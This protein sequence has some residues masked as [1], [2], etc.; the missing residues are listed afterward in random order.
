MI[1]YL[2]AIAAALSPGPAAASQAP[3]PPPAQTQP[4]QRP[5][6]AEY[7]TASDQRMTFTAARI[8]F[9]RRV[10]AVGLN[11][12][13]AFGQ[14]N[15]GLDNG[16]IYASDDHALIATVYV[17][18]PGLAHEGLTAVA[19]EHFMRIQSGAGFRPLG[20]RVTGAGGREGVAIRADFSGFRDANEASSSAFL[21]AGRW[22]VKLRV[23]GP[24]S[25]RADV[26]RTM[27]ALLEEIRFEGDIV[28][29]AAEPIALVDCPPAAA[30]PAAAL[31]ATNAADA[32]EDAIMAVAVGLHDDRRA[33]ATER[34]ADPPRFAPRWCVSSLRQAG[35]YALPTLRALPSAPT[36]DSRRSVAVAILNDSSGVVEVVER[37]FRNRSRYILLHHSTGQTRVL[38]AYDALPGDAQLNAVLGGTDAAGG[39]VRATIDYQANGDSNVTLHVAPDGAP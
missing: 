17:Y 23:S 28:P 11:R 8:S 9:P 1:R 20:S 18:L 15:V 32:M 5:D 29:R 33:G 22:I 36:E 2:L 24:E 27:T 16:L 14:R 12:S 34:R 30:A 37:R 35:R 38:G 13:I 10:G 25:R 19:T 3:S 4:P 6:G 21:K 7:W 39:Q 26:E 31:L